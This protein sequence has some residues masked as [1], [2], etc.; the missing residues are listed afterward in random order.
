MTEPEPDRPIVAHVI[1]RGFWR[2]LLASLP[3]PVFAFRNESVFRVMLH[4]TGFVLPIADAEPA[5]GFV[6]TFFVAA[7]T[8]RAA[9]S[10]ARTRVLQEWVRHGA[11]RSS[12]SHPVLEVEEIV[13]LSI[14]FRWRSGGGF[15]FYNQGAE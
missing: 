7:D 9:E 5:R 3:W 11:D 12:G 6:T 2:D 8:I 15:L 4:G 14:R 1:G 13:A 10:K